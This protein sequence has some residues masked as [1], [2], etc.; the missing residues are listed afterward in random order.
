MPFCNHIIYR[1]NYV[2]SYR[3]KRYTEQKLLSA[4]Q[5]REGVPARILAA[6][7]KGTDAKGNKF[8][9]AWLFTGVLQQV[10]LGGTL[11]LGGTL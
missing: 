1:N 8:K 5:Q 3:A 10:W 7:G 11:V 2:K 4:P 9:Y 6:A